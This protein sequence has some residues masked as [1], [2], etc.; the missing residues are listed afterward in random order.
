MSEQRKW[1]PASEF[2]VLGE[3]EAHVWVA[4]LAG[5]EEPRAGG[6]AAGARGRS[7]AV[8]GLLRA[9]LGR[10]LGAEPEELS[11]VYGP[12]GKPALAGEG[13]AV[14]FNVSHAGEVALLAF[15]AKREV[16]VDVERVREVPRAERMVGRFFPPA[17]ARAWLALPAGERCEAFVR[18]WTRL[19]SVAKLTGEGVWRTVL[20][21][22]GEGAAAA[23][24]SFDLRPHP[25]YVGTLAVEG[26]AVRLRTLRYQEGLLSRSDSKSS[27]ESGGEK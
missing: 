24:C 2:P 9:L 10:Y 4:S 11:F 21:R 8:R 18:E 25:G 13:R 6:P 20:G 14:R 17:A 15:A 12:H 27:G 5:V 3:G 26:E 19:E 22:A 23:G 1:L 7:E 16:G